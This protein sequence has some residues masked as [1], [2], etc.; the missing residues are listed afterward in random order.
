MRRALFPDPPRRI[1]GQRLLGVALRTAHLL[2]VG[3]LLG[4]HV[5]DVEP[6]RLVPFLVAAI[7]TGAGMIV[8]EIAGTC[9]WLLMG[10]GLAAVLK[11]ALILLVLVFW[12][13]RV[14]LLVAATV[15]AGVG[16]HMPGRFRH[17]VVLDWRRRAA[18]AASPAGASPGK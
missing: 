2:T 4:G 8:L 12:D 13:Q 16:S 17:A 6:A 14:P 10:K 7:V 11:I 18:A 5:F 1:P 9:E 3:T 15:V